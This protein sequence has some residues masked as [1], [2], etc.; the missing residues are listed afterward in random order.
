MYV[1]T[2]GAGFIGSNIVRALNERG[3]RDVLVVDELES[4]GRHGNI[5]DCQIADYVDKQ[6]FLKSLQSGRFARRLRSVI[7]KGACS[8]TMEQDARYVM[9]NNYEYSK[10]LLHF[11][12][13]EQVPFIYAS[14]GAVYGVAGVFREAEGHEV[15]L[16][17]YAS[18]KSLF[19]QYVRRLLPE[20]T[21]QIVGLR[22]FNV[23]GPGEQHKGRT[24]SVAFHFFNQY[25]RTGRVRLFRGSDGYGD[26]EQ[27]RDFVSVE[28]AVKVNL[29]FL[30]H[31]DKDGIFNVGSGHARSFNDMAVTV[32]NS[33]RRLE[34]RDELPLQQLLSEGAIEYIDF[35]AGLED[36]YQSFTQADVGALRAIGFTRRF[37][38]LEEGVRRYVHVLMGGARGEREAMLIG[39]G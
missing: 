2:G 21:A 23:Y 20:R 35:P 30:D 24:A 10:A 14:S 36:Q 18:S 38:S 11:C 9:E 22:Y 15:P 3:V 32:I 8:D 31:P 5:V 12:Q 16:N 34:G 29:F 7:H 6:D 25:R 28:D 37:L 13:Q 26:G 33:V 19:D 39:D 4:G 27:R 17:P 1:V